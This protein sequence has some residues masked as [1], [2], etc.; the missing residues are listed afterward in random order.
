[1]LNQYSREPGRVL[2]KQGNCLNIAVETG[3]KSWKMYVLKIMPSAIEQ[4]SKLT[5]SMNQADFVKTGKNG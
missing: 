1:M 4:R 2:D 5:L 3:Q